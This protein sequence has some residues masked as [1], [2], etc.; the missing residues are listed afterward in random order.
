MRR[1]NRGAGVKDLLI[2]ALC[3]PKGLAPI[4]QVYLQGVLV[5]KNSR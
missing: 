1:R 4:V 2:P 5:G 3:L